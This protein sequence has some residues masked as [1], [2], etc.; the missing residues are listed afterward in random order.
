[1]GE[2]TV[3]ALTGEEVQPIT[4][5]REKESLSYIE[6][7]PQQEWFV[8]VKAPNGQVQWFLRF[9]VT[10][11]QI[12]RF[13]P[14]GT[15]RQCLRFLNEAIQELFDAFSEIERVQEEYQLPKR[16]FEGERYCYPLPEQAV[17]LHAPSIRQKGR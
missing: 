1:M 14:F 2:A 4:K 3:L 17:S 15:K 12:R 5:G 13:G 6:E 9:A 7:R 16:T 10:G 8:K 11:R